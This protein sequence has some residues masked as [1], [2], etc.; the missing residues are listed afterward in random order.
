MSRRTRKGQA[1][2][3]D[4]QDQAKDLSHRL[5]LEETEEGKRRMEDS[6]RREDKAVVKPH[7]QHLSDSENE[8][9]FAGRI[10][11]KSAFVPKSNANTLASLT[12]NIHSKIERSQSCNDTVYECRTRSQKAAPLLHKAKASPGG[13]AP[14]GMLGVLLSTE[15]SRSFS[16]P[17]LTSEKRLAGN[18]LNSFIP[19]QKPERSISPDSNDSISEELNHFKPIVCSPCTPPKR[20]PDG[21]VL[22]PVII[23][24][25]P[26]NLRKSLQKPTTYEASPLILKKWEQIFQDR[27]MKKTLSKGT[28]TSVDEGLPVQSKAAASSK[29][30]LDQNSTISSTGTN[31]EFLPSSSKG[32]LVKR[33]EG[34]QDSQ[35]ND[36]FPGSGQSSETTHAKDFLNTDANS[37]EYA[38]TKVSNAKTV[39][40]YVGPTSLKPTLKR[41]HKTA[42]QTV[43]MQNGTCCTA[44]ENISPVFQLRRGQ[45]RR[46]KTKH[47][48]QNGSLKRLKAPRGEGCAQGFSFVWREA[49]ERLHQEEE[50]EKLALKLQKIF[51]KEHRAVNRCK[52]SR[53]EYPLRSKST[54]G[55]N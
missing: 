38:S 52:G 50:D 41:A 35:G 42:S 36:S 34:R 53:D 46:C 3:S 48:E 47:L 9:P 12:W 19:L 45:K 32:V 37:N 5:P 51:D 31:S 21:Q 25:T 49:E 17:A 44:A 23:K 29:H 30:L 16:A 14:F 6:L 13:W 1:Q 10:P 2:V 20:L 43:N 8:E 26:R 28:L 18:P 15:N 54:A 7:L 4:D 27:Q 40:K 24:S 33:D 39:R 55:A 11:Y 22:S